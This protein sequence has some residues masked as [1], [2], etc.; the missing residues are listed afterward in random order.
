MGSGYYYE[1]D[2][3]K[4]FFETSGLNEFY[5]DAEGRRKLYGHPVPMSRE[6]EE[7]GIHGLSAELY[8]PKC[9]KVYDLIVQEFETP[10]WLVWAHP[11]EPKDEYKQEGAVKCPD[12]GN[13]DLVL[14]NRD[15]DAVPLPCPRCPDGKM[16]FGERCQS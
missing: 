1:C 6:A 10:T 3:C 16:I 8:C 14:D 13:T 5:R 11:P 2:K 15:R 9:D 12:C 7:R 4:H